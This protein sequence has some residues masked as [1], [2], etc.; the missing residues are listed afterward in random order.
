MPMEL[1]GSTILIADDEAPICELLKDILEQEGARTRMAASGSEA[2]TALADEEPDVAILDVRMPPP[3]GLAGTSGNYLG[4]VATIGGKVVL[5]L[6]VA[7]VLT[8]TG[9]LPASVPATVP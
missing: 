9:D 5:I 6:D 4:G 8:H 1:D 3:D 2:L 7:E